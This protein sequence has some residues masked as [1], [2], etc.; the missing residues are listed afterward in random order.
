[1]VAINFVLIFIYLY[2]LSSI[3]GKEELPI[4]ILEYPKKK[5]KKRTKSKTRIEDY[6]K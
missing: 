1:M 5:K 3:P 6:R 4:F 2:L